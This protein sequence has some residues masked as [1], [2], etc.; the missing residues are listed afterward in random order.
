[1][2]I[3]Y[4]CKVPKERSE[5]SIDNAREDGLYYCCKRC[6]SEQYAER[7]RKNP[8]YWKDR[9]LKAR[10][11]ISLVEKNI[12][13][14]E[15]GGKCAV[16]NE[17]MKRP[18]VDH[19]HTTGKIRGILCGPCNQGIGLLKESPQVLL[20]AITYLALDKGLISTT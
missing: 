19:C 4:K 5:F 11:G 20:S 18:H 7:A 1:M 9:A 14:A 3:C 6:T 15:Q 16:C 2:K 13:I 17:I 8:G 10:L 12:L